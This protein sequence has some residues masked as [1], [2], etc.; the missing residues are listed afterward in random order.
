MKES[1]ILQMWRYVGLDFGSPS[2][3][4]DWIVAL[5]ILRG[6]HIRAEGDVLVGPFY[7][8]QR[9]IMDVICRTRDQRC[10]HGDGS[11]SQATKG[12]VK[13]AKGWTSNGA[14]TGDLQMHIAIEFNILVYDFQ[15][16]IWNILGAAKG[17]HEAVSC[18]ELIRRRIGVVMSYAKELCMLN[19]PEDALFWEEIARGLSKKIGHCLDTKDCT[20]CQ[21]Y[22]NKLN[23]G[24]KRLDAWMSMKYH[25]INGLYEILLSPEFDFQDEAMAQGATSE[26]VKAHTCSNLIELTSI[27]QNS[28]ADIG[29]WKKKTGQD[30][31]NT[32]IAQMDKETKILVSDIKRLAAEPSGMDPFR[33]RYGAVNIGMLDGYVALY[34]RGMKPSSWD[35]SDPIKLAQGVECFV[36]GHTKLFE[37]INY[38]TV[39]DNT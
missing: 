10:L 23:E 7:S 20:P 34:D 13:I 30:D 18:Y 28:R 24:K 22:S 14:K 3:N 38:S 27:V 4:F 32:I 12:A 5:I 17:K 15:V 33:A 39:F 31:I 11:W 6:G 9:G 21:E 35:S 26:Q 29:D 36:I 37:A 16:L 19:C 2:L 1:W 25:P 8:W